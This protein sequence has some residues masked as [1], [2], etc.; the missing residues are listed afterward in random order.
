MKNLLVQRRVVGHID[1]R[2]AAS[3]A[4]NASDA[5]GACSPRVVFSRVQP[6]RDNSG[7]QLLGDPLLIVVRWLAMVEDEIDWPKQRAE[8]RFWA[9]GGS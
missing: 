4:E 6:V 8:A 5:H 7:H 2:H 9:R 3:L 1:Q